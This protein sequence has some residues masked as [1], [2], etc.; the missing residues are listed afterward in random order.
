MEQ[1]RFFLIAIVF[2]SCTGFLAARPVGF[3]I[4][5]MAVAPFADD[6]ESLGDVADQYRDTDPDRMLSGVEMELLIGS[7]GLGIRHVAR[8]DAF[9][10]D[11]PV[12]R[13]QAGTDT[14]WW[15]DQ[16]SDLFFSYHVFGIGS[17]IDPYVRYG[18]GFAARIDVDDGAYYDETNDEWTVSRRDAYG[19]SDSIR[20]ASLYQYLGIGIQTNL[21][22]LVVGFGV[23]YTVLNQGVE[24][25]DSDW[26]LYPNERFEGRL[27]GGIAL[28][29]G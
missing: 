29:G 23:N 5:G 27:Y 2:L 26:G 21:R 13:E 11:D 16:R 20:S 8:F 12:V 28:G 7:F 17:F 14:D 25:D 1:K 3:Q 6:P 22:G 10:I 19:D 4:V 18:L 24:P 15:L 9:E